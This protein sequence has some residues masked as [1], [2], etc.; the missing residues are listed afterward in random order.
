MDGTYIEHQII[1]SARRIYL[2]G[3]HG[4]QYEAPALAITAIRHVMHISKQAYPNDCPHPDFYGLDAYE[5]DLA[6]WISKVLEKYGDRA[7]EGE[8]FLKTAINSSVMYYGLSTPL[9]AR[10]HQRLMLSVHF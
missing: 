8:N 6:A 3:I 10:V 7:G 4:T 1:D 9:E 2:T 5:Q